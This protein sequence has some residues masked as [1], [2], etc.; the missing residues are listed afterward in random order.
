MKHTNAQTEKLRP[1]AGGIHDRD[2]NTTGR[3][4]FRHNC[5]APSRLDIIQTMT[6]STAPTGKAQINGRYNAPAPKNLCGPIT[7]QMTEP[8]K[9][10][11]AI[12]QVKPLT[13]SSVQMPRTL[14]K[15]QLRTPIW[16]NDEA[17][18]AR[19]WTLNNIRRGMFMYRPSLRSEQNLSA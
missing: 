7:P 17:I 1:V 15:A 8:L 10:T 14:S 9:W 18:V 4:I 2:P 19:I 3:L 12:G 6:G 13:A 5:D 11:R 16:A